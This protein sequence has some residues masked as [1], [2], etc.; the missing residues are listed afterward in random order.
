MKITKLIVTSC[1]RWWRYA[2]RKCSKTFQFWNKRFKSRENV[3]NRKFNALLMNIRFFSV[4]RQDFTV[5]C[6]RENIMKILSHDWNK[7]YVHSKA[8]NILYLLHAISFFRIVKES[9][10]Q[11]I[12]EC[13][14][15]LSWS[16]P[17][18]DSQ[19]L[20][21]SH[22][23]MLWIIICWTRQWNNMMLIWKMFSLG[24]TSVI[25]KV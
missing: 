7:F 25:M 3:I 17:W 5:L 20:T 6:T 14:R 9:I 23:R 12:E 8:F 13:R 24:Q 18:I 16:F 19:I 1:F 11:K 21:E 22:T 2:A 10:S 4:V 15:I